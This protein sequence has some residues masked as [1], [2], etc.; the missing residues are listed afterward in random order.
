MASCAAEIIF[1]NG[2]VWGGGGGQT[3]ETGHETLSRSADTLL[4]SIYCTR[5]HAE[6]A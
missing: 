6:Q 1:V 2:V 5:V 3:D 4:S